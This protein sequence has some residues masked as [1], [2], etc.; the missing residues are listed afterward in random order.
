MKRGDV[1]IVSAG[2]PYTGKARPAVVVQND[3][4]NPWHD[5]VTVCPLTTTLADSPR[6]R[7]GVLAS[8]ANG[9]T[10]TSQLMVD[11][12]VTLPKPRVRATGG[13]IDDAAIA[14]LDDALRDWLAL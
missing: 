4:Y 11:K 1:V 7:F 2:G 10:A 9:L 13:R 5:S 6:F 8:E 3:A 14:A 12:L